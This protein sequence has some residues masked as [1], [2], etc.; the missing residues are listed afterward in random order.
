MSRRPSAQPESQNQDKDL[1]D[2]RGRT[3][4]SCKKNTLFQRSEPLFI[5]LSFTHYVALPSSEGLIS[6]AMTLCLLF[7]ACWLEIET[8]FSLKNDF[9]IKICNF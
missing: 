3:K 5:F 4:M 2:G 8:G 7:I 1:S 9:Y 6:L